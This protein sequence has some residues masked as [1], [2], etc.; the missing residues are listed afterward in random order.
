MV[1]GQALAI[2]AK[3]G[4]TLEHVLFNHQIDE[5]KKGSEN[6]NSDLVRFQKYKMTKSMVMYLQGENSQFGR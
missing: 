6:L 4:F 1:L 2:L 3:A 5:P